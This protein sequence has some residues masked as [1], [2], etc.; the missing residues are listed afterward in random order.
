MDADWLLDVVRRYD[1]LGVHRTGTDVDW[2]TAQCLVSL[3]GDAGAA[4]VEIER[5]PFDRWESSVEAHADDGAP[6]VAEPLWG[7][8]AGCFDASVAVGTLRTAV[9]DMSFIRAASS[10]ASAVDRARRDGVGALVVA[11]G[12]GSDIVQINRPTLEL[13]GPPVVLVSAPDLDR[14]ASVRG[15]A[16]V[17]PGE[18]PVVTA[19]F[20]PTDPSAGPPVIVTTPLSG[21]FTCAGERGTGLAIALHVAASLAADGV[22]VRFIASSGHEL[23]HLGTKRHL[24]AAAPGALRAVIHLGASAAAGTRDAVTGRVVLSP[25]RLALVTAGPFVDAVGEA[26]RDV[27]LVPMVDPPNWLGEAGEWV[28]RGAPTLSFTGFFDAFHTVRD[29]VDEVTD[30]D[31]L[32]AMAGAALRASR[33]V[34]SSPA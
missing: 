8:W 32:D 3:L 34:V 9:L 21:W 10:L 22:P 11:T 5:H 16:R 24:R 18:L 27:G 23:G 29:R 7:S 17:V 15:E 20:G 4:A 13:G 33:A 1:G 19:N 31:A 26:L 28:G 14:V 12:E 2:A 30:R 25:D 6:I